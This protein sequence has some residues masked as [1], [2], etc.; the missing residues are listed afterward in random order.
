[1]RKGEGNFNLISC[2]IGWRK[3]TFRRFFLGTF[4]ELFLLPII[5]YFEICSFDIKEGK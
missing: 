5:N 3:V 2:D 4:F 1:M